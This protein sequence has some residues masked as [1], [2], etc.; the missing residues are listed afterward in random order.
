MDNLVGYFF[1]S[2]LS[3]HTLK[4]PNSGHSS[5]IL[6]GIVI[7]SL[8]YLRYPG[9]G[10]SG[11]GLGDVPGG[12]PLSRL[13]PDP[14]GH[15]E[16]ESRQTQKCGLCLKK[17]KV[18]QSFVLDTESDVILRQKEENRHDKFSNLV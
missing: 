10:F 8:N 4:T 7:G 2:H 9:A 6:S 5:L 13:H 14:A 11:S 3:P 15:L 1:Y 12:D 17:V 16:R 18:K